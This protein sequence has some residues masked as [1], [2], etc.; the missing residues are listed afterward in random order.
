MST[1]LASALLALILQIF[2]AQPSPAEPLTGQVIFFADGSGSMLD[3]PTPHIAF[4]TRGITTGLQN[5]VARCNKIRVT[6][7]R[8]GTEPAEPIVGDLDNK[9]QLVV[10][11]ENAS[12]T[13]L[14]DTRPSTAWRALKDVF[15]PGEP[16]A[17]VMLTNGSGK[18]PVR[19]PM[20]DAT[21]FKVAILSD[22]AF[23]YLTTQFLPG[24]SEPIYAAD[25]ES[26][27]QVVEDALR[28]VDTL[29]LG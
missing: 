29:C 9:A 6:Y 19:G 20:P 15:K 16:T 1:R 23:K 18:Y 2:A 21:L 3:G 5:Y 26:I 7:I 13:G 22:Q 25:V 11:I 8:W 28:S 17:I 24:V 12:Q 10:D 27:A 14:G 4:Q